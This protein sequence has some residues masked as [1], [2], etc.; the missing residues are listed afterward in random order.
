MLVRRIEVVVGAALLYGAGCAVGDVGEGADRASEALMMDQAVDVQTAHP[1]RNGESASWELRAPE[2]ATQLLVPFDYFDTERGYDWVDILDGAGTV[3][4]HLSGRHDGESFAVA[5]N[6]AQ[7]TFRSDRS[8]VRYGFSI[9]HFSYEVSEPVRPTDHRPYCGAVGSRSEGWYW[10]DTGELIRFERCFDMPEPECGAIGSRSEGWYAEDAGLI[11]WDT[12]HATVRIALAGEYCGPSIGFSCWDGLYCRGVPEGRIGGRG[13]CREHGYCETAADCNAEGNMWLRPM[14]MGYAVCNEEESRCGFVCGPEPL[15][16]WS[17]TTYL[18]RDVESAHPYANNTSQTWEVHHDGASSIRL[19]FDR[20][21]LEPRY[22]RLVIAG[23]HEERAIS[24]DGRHDD[25]W[26]D[27]IGG[28]TVTVTLETDRSVTDWGFRA[29][30][31]SVYEQLPVGTCNRTEDCEAGLVCNPSRCFSAYAPCY[32]TC[33]RDNHCD[34][35]TTL[36][37]RRMTP[38]C[39][40][41]TILAY[42]DSCYACVDPETC[43]APG[44]PATHGTFTASDTPLAIPDN[45]PAGVESHV[46]VSGMAEAGCSVAASVTIRHT[47]RGDLR[48]VLVAP[49]GGET[50]LHDRSGGSADDLVLSEEPLDGARSPAGAWTLRVSDRAARDVGT[51]ESF[52]LVVDCS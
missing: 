6:V 51:L 20:I 46:T 44:S 4:H 2:E 50:V 17:W 29:T 34:D 19:H 9:S 49:D 42:Q 16:P 30:E 14:C 21:A 22:D 37:C 45:S 43:E 11:V 35:G 31:V 28:D 48:V 12:C 52:S 32:G 8:I 33:I 39:P 24:I 47:Y 1:Y 27:E 25:Y 26:T 15:G 38:V 23:T 13:V 36:A 7:I 40:A 18:L 3:I 10:G 5:G 41:G